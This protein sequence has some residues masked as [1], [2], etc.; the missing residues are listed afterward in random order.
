MRSTSVVVSSVA[1]KRLRIVLAVC[2][3]IATQTTSAQTTFCPDSDGNGYVGMSD[4]MAFLAA[5]NLPWPPAVELDCGGT[6][7][8][9]GYD[10]ETVAIGNQCWFAENVRYLPEVFPPSQGWEDSYG[11]HAY[12]LDYH[13]S[14]VAAAMAT[15]GYQTYGV[16]YDGPAVQSWTLCPAGWHLPTSAEWLSLLNEVGGQTT[17]APA[18]KASS[19][20]NGTN[21]SGFNALPGGSRSSAVGFL[22]DGSNAWFWGAEAFGNYSGQGLQLYTYANGTVLDQVYTG[23][24]RC[25]QD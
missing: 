1:M 20:W 25:I 17:A 22:F 14:D 7:S 16:I 13:G 23:H 11:A 8:F 15:T 19:G 21:S 12:V 18:L 2:V 24:V 4:L 6:V 5:Y 3:G 10:Y 9:E